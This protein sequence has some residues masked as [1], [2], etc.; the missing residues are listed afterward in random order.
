[1]KHIC[2]LAFSIAM[3]AVAAAAAQKAVDIDSIKNKVSIRLG[4][5]CHEFALSPKES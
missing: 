4:Q 5:E 2:T 1:M 3:A